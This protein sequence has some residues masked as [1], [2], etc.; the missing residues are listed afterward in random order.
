MLRFAH[1]R[2]M[3]RGKPL[4]LLVIPDNAQLASERSR[5]FGTLLNHGGPDLML[6]LAMCELA[7]ARTAEA[8]EIL[9]TEAIDGEPLLLLFDFKAPG[10]KPVRKP[11]PFTTID[12]KLLR[13]KERIGHDYKSVL[14]AQNRHAITN[15][16]R[17]A[18]ALMKA[19]AADAGALAIRADRV[20]VRLAD[21]DRASIQS[22]VDGERSIRPELAIHAA[23]I[24]RM[25]ALVQ[26]RGDDD[27]R[28]LGAIRSAVKKV[29]VKQHIADSRWA[30]SSGC[31]V[32][33][34]GD[35]ALRVGSGGGHVSAPSK[36]FFY[37][38]DQ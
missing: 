23:A 33:I 12:P 35:S 14:A 7:C 31:G 29:F 15:N 8:E 25:S 3:S 19:L 20:R 37:H 6:D 28:I 26:G 9:G 11:L 5:L 32:S 16:A 24:L 30:H 38:C 2:A 21:E 13:E 4:L 27:E 17:I 36:R 18:T 10:T 22:F 1:L 34:E